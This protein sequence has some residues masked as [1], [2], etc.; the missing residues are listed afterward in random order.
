MNPDNANEVNHAAEVKPAGEDAEPGEGVEPEIV[1]TDRRFWA[2]PGV[3]E[4][5][6]A[7]RSPAMSRSWRSRWLTRTP[8]C[9]PP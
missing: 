9:K 8:A 5:T 2:R 7:P 6:E 3:E 4:A 1:V